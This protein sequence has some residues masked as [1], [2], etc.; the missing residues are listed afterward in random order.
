MKFKDEK[1]H[2][3]ILRDIA[4]RVMLERGLLPDFSPEVLAEIDKIKGPAV[5]TDESVRDL[6]NLLWCS[7]DNDDSRDLDQITVANLMPDG[8]IK[9]LSP[10]PMSTPLSENPP[11]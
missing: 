2:K 6:R 5:Q 3:A 8:N 4:H 9:V 11:K 1:Q 10:S 7:I